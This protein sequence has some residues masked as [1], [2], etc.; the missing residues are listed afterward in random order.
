MS[1]LVSIVTPLFNSE[2]YIRE[3]IDSV[4][5]QTYCKWEMIIVDDYS[6]DNSYSIAE[7][8]VKIDKRIKLFKL[9]KNMGSGV[10]RNFAIEK[11]KGSIIA[12]LD[13]DDLWHPQK[14]ELHLAEMQK[15]KAGFS[16]T[17]YGYILT[18]GTVS[19]KISKVSRKWVTYNDLLRY[20]EISCLTAMYD[21]RVLGKM[22]MPIY[23]RKQDYGLW[24]NI[25][26]SGVN[27]FPVDIPLAWYRQ[28]K[29]SSS[30]KK[31]KLVFQHY[32]FLRNSQDLG[33]LKSVQYTLLW[34]ING[35]RKYYI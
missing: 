1:T 33:V 35:I 7:E 20:T 29:G 26:K 6:T 34:I 22:Y 11:A 5:S 3:C 19:N 16:H 8:F 30:S 9:S 23:R 24:L 2:K 10:A 25:L 32:F 13:S 28:V 27:S 21:V 14:L 17:S 4:L 31:Y 15:N 12:F 18:D